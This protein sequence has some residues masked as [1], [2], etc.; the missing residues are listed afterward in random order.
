MKREFLM[1]AHNYDSE[2][3]GVAGWFVSEKLDGMRCWWDG[4]V[5][6]GLLA[7]SVP[8]ANTAKDHR[9]LAAP[10]AT[11]LWSR[12]GHVIHAPAAWLDKL[13]PICLD[14]ELYGGRGQFQ[15]VMSTVKKHTPNDTDW[16]NIRYRVFDV[17]PVGTVLADGVIANTNYKKKLAGCWDWWS[18]RVTAVQPSIYDFEGAVGYMTRSIPALMHEQV[19]LPFDTV[20]AR[21]ELDKMLIAVTTGGGEGL[22]LRKPTSSWVPGRTHDLLKVKKLMDMEGE[23]IGYVAGE[24]TT[25]GSKLLGLMGSLM[26]RLANG[27]VFNLSGFTDQERILVGDRQYIEDMA[28]A[29]LDVGLARSDVF[30]IGSMVTFQYREMTDAGLPKEARYWRK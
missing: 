4:G 10:V 5:S 16:A 23:V 20:A 13:P 9:L 1:L 28:G 19:R 14:G 24:R 22:M 3:H 29:V 18:G 25:L 11:G 15:A 6:R 12:Y 21:A 17:P 26:V 30:P 7:N 8:W 2:R 27:N